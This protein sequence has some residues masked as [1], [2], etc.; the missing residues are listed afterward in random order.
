MN[1]DNY[2]IELKHIRKCYEK[3]T[4]VI[5]DYNLQVKKG[6]FV[7]FL[8]PSGCGKTTIL[9]M[10]AGFEEPTSGEILFHGEDISHLPPH[11]RPVNTV[12]QH[13]AL[14]PHLSV[15]ENIAFGLKQ[16]KLDRAVIAAKV[17]RVLSIVDL[18]GFE[19]R[20]IGSLSGGQQQRVAIARAIVNEPEILLLDEPLGAL[21]FKMRQ[22]M[23]LELKQMHD[24]LG[25]TFIFVTHDQEEALTMSDKIVV[26]AG[27]VI[28][29]VGTPEQIY[30][31]P[32]NAFVA[33][34]IGESNI[35]NGVK[36][37]ADQVRF[38]DT[39]F[40]CQDDYPRGTV[41]DV[42]IR[43]EDI[44]LTRAGAGLLDGTVISS[45]FRGKYYDVTIQ[46]GDNEFISQ[47]TREFAVGTVVGL[48]IEAEGIHNVPYDLS[49]NHFVAT[50]DARGALWFND[51][52][53]P[54]DIKR[55]F[56]GAQVQGDGLVSDQGEAIQTVGVQVEFAFSPKFAR[57]SDNPEEGCFHG[58]ITSI[59]YMGDHY[60]YRVTGDNNEEYAVDDKWL[61]NVGDAVSVVVPPD[62]FRCRLVEAEEEE[63]LP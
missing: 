4:P 33:D 41:V 59:I 16:K 8:G 32:E 48:V 12:F 55:V 50:A 13:Y 60:N 63:A 56:P 57:L 30:N 18:E 22:E 19:K 49:I 2:I 61:W 7:T 29:Q 3:D 43:P 17:G 46:C 38:A 6:E 39:V 14:F 9:R 52:L 28:Q 31:T 15:F 37:A 54:I 20:R 1:K 62:R 58:N 51:T 27:G 47:N 26:M 44:G 11:K 45:I 23:Q 21:D 25:I 53:V 36:T 40:P 24:D 35:F 10:I 42:I 34:F 5:F